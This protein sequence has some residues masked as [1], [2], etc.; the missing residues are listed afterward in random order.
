VARRAVPLRLQSFL[1]TFA[2]HLR[3]YKRRRRKVENC[4]ALKFIV[5]LIK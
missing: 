2:L 5:T 3:Q 1:S 4:E